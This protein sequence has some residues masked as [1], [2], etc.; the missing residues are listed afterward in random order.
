M[1]ALSARLN[2]GQWG[3][4]MK[5][6]TAPGPDAVDEIPERAADDQP[7]REPQQPPVR[8]R[9]KNAS[10]AATITS[11]TID[12]DDLAA[13]QQAERDAAV[14]GVDE[15]DA[16][17]ARGGWS[18]ERDRARHERLGDLVADEHQ[19]GDE[20]GPAPRWPRAHGRIADAT[21]RAADLQHDDRDQRAEVEAAERRQHAPEDAQV[22]LGDVAQE[23]EHG[24]APAR[25]GDPQPDPE[26]DARQHVGD[27]HECVDRRQ[28]DDVVARRARRS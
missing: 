8:W 1:I 4:W 28:R 25:V 15:R 13:G 21:S 9:A 16:R 23:R 7:G 20:P 27:D 24:I 18:P 22:R 14:L 3:S 17:A 12:D 6:V 26:G 10:T 11:V 5:S 19:R 2:A